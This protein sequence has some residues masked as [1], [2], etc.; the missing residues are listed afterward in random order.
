[1][2]QLKTVFA[3]IAT[4]IGAGFASGQ[5]ISTFFYVYGMNGIAGL[6]MC[7]FLFAVIIYKVL[8]IAQSNN[9]ENYKDFMQL[10][11]GK[12]GFIVNLIVNIFLL[13]TFFI[14]IAGFGAYFAQ[15]VQISTYI[16]SGILAC[17]CFFTFITNTNGVLK[18]SSILVPIL[19]FFIV[20]I[21]FINFNNLDKNAMPNLLSNMNANNLGWL[22]SSILYGSYNSILLIPVLLTLKKHVNTK[23]DSI[24]VALFS[25]VILLILSLS[26]FFILTKVNVDITKLEM[27]VIYVIRNFYKSFMHI[28]AFIILTSIYTTAISLGMSFLQNTFSHTRFYPQVVL[29][30]CITGF[31]ISGYGFSNLVS[32]L[33]PIFGYFGL[34]QI[35]LL[36]F[37]SSY[38]PNNNAGKNY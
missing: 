18:V 38:L 14:M 31:L 26:I 9:I 30:M 27:P 21:G 23:K 10:L 33:Y 36:F 3:I 28:Y 16:G 7:N 29:I 4:L 13:I 32:T 8:C 34:L 25:G 6:V 37:S 11:V 19:I 24:T 1:M 22:L 35:A 2:K 15:E 12:N 20:L 5:E 17:L